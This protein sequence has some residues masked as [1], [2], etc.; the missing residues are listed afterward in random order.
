MTMSPSLRG[1]LT[2]ALIAVI[3]TLAQAQ[4]SVLSSTVE[5]REVALGQTYTGRIVIANTS[6]LP[7]AVRLYQ[8]DY[9]FKA[10]GTSIFG[11]PGT[12]A[13][14]NA[15]WIT[16]QATRVTVPPNA[17]ITVPY[18]IKVPETDSLGGTYWSAIMVEGAEAPPPPTAGRAG[19]AQVGIGS[20][21]R[22]AVQVATHIGKTG[23]GAVKFENPQ[24]LKTADGNAA[25]D[26]DVISSGSRGVRP[27]MSVELYDAQGA[28]KGKGKQVRGLLY[29]GTSLH[30]HFEFGAL[31]A[32]TYKAIV[33]ADIGSE[34]VTAVQ[35]T[36]TY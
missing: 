14:S 7:Q 6:P 33:F 36:I 30:Q 1:C 21:I 25:L 20:V 12:S 17:E 29:P 24:A 22:Y 31:P 28:L 18:S 15:G 34:K 4:V 8:T 2:G 27:T 11:D 10:D 9:S 5:E 26:I 35:I 16:P 23:M 13:R 3:P 32:G 19:Q